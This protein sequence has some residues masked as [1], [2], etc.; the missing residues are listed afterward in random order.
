MSILGPAASY[1]I[2][3]TLFCE[4]EI[5]RAIQERGGKDAMILSFYLRAN[6]HANMLGLYRLV[7]GDVVN[8]LPVLVSTGAVLRAFAG[9]S[10]AAWADYDE[11]TAFVWVRRMVLERL[12]L[13]AVNQV[14]DPED[15]RR[16]G[17]QR[18]YDGVPPNPFLEPFFN[19][20]GRTLRLERRVFSQP[21]LDVTPVTP[22]TPPRDVIAEPSVIDRISTEGASQGASQ[23][24]SAGTCT[25]V[26]VL[27]DQTDQIDQVLR[28]ESTPRTQPRLPIPQ[29]LK[30]DRRDRA[31]RE[32]NGNNYHVIC[33]VARD[34]LADPALASK[35]LESPIETEGDLVE[36]TKRFCA[37]KKI[38]Y[39]RRDSVPF[40]VAYRACNWEW[41]KARVA[42]APAMARRRRQ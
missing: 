32:P 30:D 16:R 26:L 13:G 37:A 6:R 9:L 29:G 41:L 40:D 38:D 18:L 2:L 15:K 10:S 5:S 8:E 28:S 19:L 42:G 11:R 21:T 1:G 20:Y 14:L 3:P 24:A 34:L 31:S 12:N 25:Q 22:V 17:A 35:Y 36:A 33:R 23:G 27:S 4:S 39:G 7:L